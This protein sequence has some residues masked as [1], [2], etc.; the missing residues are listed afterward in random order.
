MKPL[1]FIIIIILGITLVSCENKNTS[2]EYPYEAEVLGK[3][4][5]CGIYAIKFTNNLDQI[6]KIADTDS[7]S[8]IYIA[9]NLPAELQVEGLIIE[10]NVR[11][12]QG[13]ELGVCTTMGPGY[14]W[15]YILSAR[16][17]E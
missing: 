15:I 11:K 4:M 6:Q 3:N 8:A 9:K 13:T 17:I 10:L 2:Q 16:K 12:I 5:D 7:P 14:P 1:L